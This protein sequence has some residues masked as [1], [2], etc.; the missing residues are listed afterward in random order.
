MRKYKGLSSRQGPRSVSE[1]L[2]GSW[3]LISIFPTQPIFTNTATAMLSTVRGPLC[4]TI[5]TTIHKCYQM[6]YTFVREILKD[7]KLWARDSSVLNCLSHKSWVKMSQV[8][9]ATGVK[10]LAW[11]SG[12][13]KI[14]T[15][16]MSEH[17]LN[18]N[19]NIYIPSLKWKICMK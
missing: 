10:F 19:M 3:L 18:W 2:F 15:N 6:A 8:P 13:V 12:C 9:H 1:E 7:G 4:D 17:K 11:K 16:I 14:L 5:F